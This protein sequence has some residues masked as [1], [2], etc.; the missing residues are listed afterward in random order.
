M[1]KNLIKKKVDEIAKITEKISNSDCVQLKKDLEKIKLMLQSELDQQTNELKNLLIERKNVEKQLILFSRAA[2]QSSS[3]IVITDADGNIKYVNKKFEKI[4]GF[5]FEQVFDKN[6]RI[7]KSGEQSEDYYKDLWQ[8]IKSGKDWTGELHNKRK[9]GELYWERVAISPIKNNDGIITHFIAIKDDITQKKL[10]EEQLKKSEQKYRRIFE[11]LIDVFYRVSIQG[12]IE[13]ISPSISFVTQYKPE[14]LIGKPSEIFYKDSK[15]REKFLAEI[16]KNGSIKNFETEMRDKDNSIKLISFNSKVIFNEKGEP[17]AIEGI[18][19]DVT[20]IREAQHKLIESEKRLKEEILTKDKFFNIIAHDL[21]S[22]FTAL[23]GMT[24]MLNESFNEFTIDEVKESIRTIQSSSENIFSLLED[25]LEW[26]RAQRSGV[27]YN[28][29]NIMLYQICSRVISL[30]SDSAK[31]K[32][33]VISCSIDE[34]QTIIADE[35]YVFTILRNLIVNA[36]KFTR[37]RGKIE[38]LFKEDENSHYISV[39]DNGIGMHVSDIKK[40]FK[41][42]EFHTTPGTENEKGTGFGLLLCKDLAKKQGGDLTVESELGLGSI[43]TLRIP[44]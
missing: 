7:L 43:F 19:R 17:E 10:T 33:I 29:T 34:K 40:I 27:V 25:L 42:N 41:M 39:K 9:N 24:R 20:K 1:S 44:K 8:T 36:I 15:G 6:P 12:I 5:L 21:R 28:P 13:I 3:S 31:Q 32:G 38:I 18:F 23:L 22:P 4:T 30:N 37:K 14:E 16:L 11:N 35:D 2:E 26:S